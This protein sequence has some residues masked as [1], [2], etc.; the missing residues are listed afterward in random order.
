MFTLPGTIGIVCMN[1]KSRH[2][3]TIDTMSRVI[4]DS[5]LCEEDVSTKLGI[6]AAD[7]QEALHVT[8]VS[9]DRDVV[10]FRCRECRTGFQTTISLFETYQ[11]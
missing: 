4:G 3:L 5:E 1:C 9:V 8:E 2:R 7:H 11:P 10:Q 6:C